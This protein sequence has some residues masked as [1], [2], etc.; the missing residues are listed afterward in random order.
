DY[1]TLKALLAEM[2]PRERSSNIM[3]WETGGQSSNKV[4]DQRSGCRGAVGDQTC[5][6]GVGIIIKILVSQQFFLYQVLLDFLNINEKFQDLSKGS[7]EPS[8]REFEE[9]HSQVASLCNRINNLPCATAKDRLCQ[10]EL[11]KQC[12][13]YL[14]LTTSELGVTGCLHAT[15]CSM[16]W[17]A[18]YY[19]GH[20]WGQTLVG[21]YLSS[22]HD[23]EQIAVAQRN[24]WSSG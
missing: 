19:I 16:D 4:W 3:G 7:C 2:A 18:I 15:I 24:M 12:A 14:K 9:I 10:Y 22:S 6:G 13:S 21:H 20:G 23:L 11:A 8:K 17:N 5:V 1:D